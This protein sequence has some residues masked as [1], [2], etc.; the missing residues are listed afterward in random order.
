[1]VSGNAPTPSPTKWDFT[2][3][4]IASRY[5]DKLRF[6]PYAFAK[7]LY[8]K[9]KGSTEVSG[10]ALTDEKDPYLVIDFIVPEQECTGA[11]TEMSADGIVA[12]F[13]RVSGPEK[14]GGMGLSPGRFG[15]IWVHTHPGFSSEPSGTDW[16][17]FRETFGGKDWA[18]MFILSDKRL[19]TCIL[20]IDVVPGGYFRIPWE[21]DWDYEFQGSAFEEWDKEY[22]DNV[23]TRSYRSY[24][25]PST[26][27]SSCNRG[28][29]GDCEKCGANM[30]LYDHLEMKLCWKCKDALK[31]DPKYASWDKAKEEDKEEVD[32]EHCD[33]CG[34]RA[35]YFYEKNGK[36]LCYD[37]NYN[38]DKGG[39]A[40]DDTDTAATDDTQA[41]VF[42]DTSGFLDEETDGPETIPDSCD[43][44]GKVTDEL[45]EWEDIWLCDA[46]FAS[47]EIEEWASEERARRTADEEVEETSTTVV[48]EEEPT[49]PLRD[50]ME[51]PDPFGRWL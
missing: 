20:Q 27:Y 38:A 9:D 14:F 41:G 37:C 7:M 34:K 16:S 49:T 10:F 42:D 6:T 25:Y 44:C 5:P 23:S 26:G 4:R 46:C 47:D 15:R 19:A 28:N 12:V 32:K 50:P 43:H 36:S 11:T 29:Y 22:K 33:K 30:Y 18:I 1:V 13:D 21:V 45:I 51:R 31:A 39:F 3:G 40:D 48:S 2:Q 8:M 17:T 35:Y 24:S